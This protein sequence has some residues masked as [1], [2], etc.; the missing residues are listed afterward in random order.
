MLNVLERTESLMR[1]WK[2]TVE[3]I[4]S[5]EILTPTADTSDFP[6]LIYN[7]ILLH[8]GEETVYVDKQNIHTIII[9]L[10]W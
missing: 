8:A 2:A 7:I 9:I 6:F 4:I 3:N 1:E 10:H 5:A